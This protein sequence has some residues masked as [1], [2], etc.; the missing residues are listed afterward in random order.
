MAASYFD[1]PDF[2]VQ[3]ELRQILNVSVGIH[4][5]EYILKNVEQRALE[6]VRMFGMEC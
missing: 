1:L 5:E 3:L 6:F 2:D 4:A